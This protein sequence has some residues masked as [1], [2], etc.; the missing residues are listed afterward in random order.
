M[1]IT[2]AWAISAHHDSVISEL[3]PRILPLIAAER[4]EPRAHERWA[5]WR[6]SPLPD[7]RTWYR[8]S[9]QDSN[10][11]HAISSFHRLTAPGEHIQ[12]LYDDTSHEDEFHLADS[13]WARDESPKHMFLA[14]RSKDYALTSFFH[15]VGPARAAFIPGWCGNFLLTAAQVR[16][17]LPNIERTLSFT[18]QERAAAE[19]QDWL[20]YAPDEESVLTGPLRQWRHAAQ[21]GLGLCGLSV[22]IY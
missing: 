3:A 16:D 5:R 10:L 1:G 13:V 20:D 17:T 15:A 8:I 18:P 22:L 11:A 9:A 7:H 2:S 12:R 6:H 14:I 19:K 4:E 21:A